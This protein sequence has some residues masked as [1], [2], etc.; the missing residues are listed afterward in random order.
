MLVFGSCSSIINEALVLGVISFN[1]LS[2]DGVFKKTITKL[3]ILV[4]VC[5]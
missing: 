3:F 2:L 4:N 1:S 5:F